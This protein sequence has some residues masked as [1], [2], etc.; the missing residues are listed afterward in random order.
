TLDF[1]LL[2]RHLPQQQGKRDFFSGI[3]LYPGGDARRELT[4]PPPETLDSLRRAAQ[5][6]RNM[7]AI[8]EQ[9]KK[10]PQAATRLLA[11][12]NELT[13]DLDSG[14]AGRILYHLAQQYYRTGRWPMAAETFELLI[15]R[16]PEHPLVRPALV[17][18]VQYYAG[19]E[20]AWR[21]QGTQRFTVRQTSALSIDASQQENRPDRAAQLGKQIERTCPALFADPALRFPLA[22][23]H[24]NQGFPRQAERFYFM[25]TRSATQDAW[26]ACARGEQWLAEPKGLPP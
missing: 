9:S 19:G 24:R 5:R 22:V 16:H 21:V 26:W 6:Q 17:W 20:A 2:V 23:A 25:R 18:L 10:D 4:D 15:D 13:R 3:V 8:L 7:R 1:R 11:Q 14:S 12:T